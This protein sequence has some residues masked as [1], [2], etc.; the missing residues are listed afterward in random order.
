MRRVQ[1]ATLLLLAIA[2]AASGRL[3]DVLLTARA[4]EAGAA[5][6]VGGAVAGVL[7]AVALLGLG[8]VVLRAAT[9]RSA[10]SRR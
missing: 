5:D 4:G 9:V 6:V 1:I 10:Q 8:R 7:L 2:T 3:L